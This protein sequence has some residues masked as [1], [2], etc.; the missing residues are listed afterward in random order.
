[1]LAQ[2]RPERGLHQRRATPPAGPAA[3]PRLPGDWS[4]SRRPR[5]H[6]LLTARCLG[7]TPGAG[8]KQDET[9]ELRRARIFFSI[10]PSS[11]WRPVAFLE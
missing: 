1:M 8:D 11:A 2:F 3:N 10:S 9:Q 7:H 6:R 4:I 5:G